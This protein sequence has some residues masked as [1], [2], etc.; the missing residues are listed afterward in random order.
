MFSKVYVFLFLSGMSLPTKPTPSTNFLSFLHP[1]F[2][3]IPHPLIV[4]KLAEAAALLATGTGRQDLLRA[5]RCLC[6]ASALALRGARRRGDGERLPR[7]HIFWGEFCVYHKEHVEA[8]SKWRWMVQMI[9][10]F[11]WVNFEGSMI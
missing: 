4:N 11:S 10:L 1:P 2:V 7:R 6:R 9:F 8:Q 3:G 5:F